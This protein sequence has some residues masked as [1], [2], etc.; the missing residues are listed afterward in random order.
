MPQNDILHKHFTFSKTA[1][2]QREQLTKFNCG[3]TKAQD[4]IGIATTGSGKTVAFLFPAFR[5]IIETKATPDDPLLLCLSPT[6]E[7]AVQV[8]NEAHK[9]GAS[10]KNGFKLFNQ[11][12]FLFYFFSPILLPE[13]NTVE[14][15]QSVFMEVL[16]TNAT[17]QRSLV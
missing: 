11:A 7:L 10:A 16:A 14:L 9:F 12:C 6:R 17:W 3:L 8:E 4:I 5:H 13:A 2:L 1:R 15:S